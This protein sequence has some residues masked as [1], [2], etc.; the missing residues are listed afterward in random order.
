MV[1]HGSST[2]TRKSA[3]HGQPELTGALFLGTMRAVPRC[4]RI[5]SRFLGRLLPDG[6]ITSEQRENPTTRGL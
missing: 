2:G 3:R 6:S 5:Q 4:R 1:S